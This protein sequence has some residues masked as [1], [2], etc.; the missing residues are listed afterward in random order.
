MEEKF[1]LML[2][3]I[4][5]CVTV[6]LHDWIPVGE[7]DKSSGGTYTK[8]EQFISRKD[9]G[10]GEDYD[11]LTDRLGAIPK[12]RTLGVAVELE[13]IMEEAQGRQR[14]KAFTVKMD[15]YKTREGEE[16]IA[17]VIGIINQGPK[18]FWGWLGAFDNTRAPVDET[19]MSVVRRGEG[20]DTE[21]DFFPFSDTEVDFGALGLS[22]ITT[23][24]SRSVLLCLIRGSR[25]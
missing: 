15:S 10:I 3:P 12:V 23:V 11:D 19:P 18:N 16:K 21:Y 2:T 4:D 7:R 14:P 5:Q 6:E 22:L 20:K 17:P 1:I 8:F 13:P 24:Q 25:S 9:S